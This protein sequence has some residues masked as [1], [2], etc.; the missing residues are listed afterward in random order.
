MDKFTS[1]LVNVIPTSAVNEVSTWFDLRHHL[2]ADAIIKTGLNTD[3]NPPLWLTWCVLVWNLRFPSCFRGYQNTIEVYLRQTGPRTEIR[4]KAR[5]WMAHID[6]MLVLVA[7]R[8]RS[9]AL[10]LMSHINSTINWAGHKASA[11]SL[12][13]IYGDPLNVSRGRW[14]CFSFVYGRKSLLLVCMHNFCMHFSNCY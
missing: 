3:Y 13:I 14:N 5:Q 8:S 11:L 12:L 6:P 10:T 4:H 1:I 9:T 2:N 7:V